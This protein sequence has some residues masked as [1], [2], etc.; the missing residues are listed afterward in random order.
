M[1]QIYLLDLL[2]VRW[3]A[4]YP[5]QVQRTLMAQQAAGQWRCIFKD[6]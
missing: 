1:D 3:T 5:C 6:G 2:L 4:L